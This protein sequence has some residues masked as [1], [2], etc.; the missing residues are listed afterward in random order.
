MYTAE[1]TCNAD[2]PIHQKVFVIVTYENFLNPKLPN[3]IS[4]EK[5]IKPLLLIFEEQI[6]K[7]ESLHREVNHSTKSEDEDDEDDEDEEVFI[8]EEE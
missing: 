4:K 2:T 7:N 3:I 6:K 8:N 5:I 1:K